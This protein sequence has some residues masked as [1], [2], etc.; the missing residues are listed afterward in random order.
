MLSR[1]LVALALVTTCPQRARCPEGYDLRAGVRRTGAA[2][3][4]A[5]PVGDPEWDGTWQ[6]P[7]RS[8][9]PPGRVELQ[10]FC[11]DSQPVVVDDRTIAC[12]R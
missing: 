12:K 4:W 1:I 9:Q 3:C 10:I 2:S 8:I 6:R 5:H 7:E 11:F